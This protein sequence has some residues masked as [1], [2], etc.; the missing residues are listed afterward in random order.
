MSTESSR[1]SRLFSEATRRRLR[2]TARKLRRNSKA[3]IGLAIVVGLLVLALVSPVVAPYSIE[4]TDPVNRAETPSLAHPF[5]TDELGRDVFSRALLGTRISLYVGFATVLLSGVVGTAIG[6]TSGYKKGLVDDAIVRLMDAILAF[7]P[8]LLGLV[9]VAIAGQ[10]ITNVILGLSIVFVPYFA[11]VSRSAALSESEEPYVK[12]A[13]SQGESDAYI[14]FREVLPNCMA[15]VLVQAS[16][17]V[18]WA[19]LLEA[20]LSFLGIGVQPPKPSW[21]L[22]INTARPFMES[23]PWMIVFPGLGIAL[24]VIGFNMLGDGLRDVLDAK[25][26]TDR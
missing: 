15:P 14:V 18:A 25:E 4:K 16:I 9:F 10:N 12:A 3:T 24:T 20:A 21:G 7:P 5:G 8:I 17:T 22:M 1:I 13:I 11:R 19:I 2:T 23:A 26:V 6:V